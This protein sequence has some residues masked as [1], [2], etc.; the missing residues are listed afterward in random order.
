MAEKTAIVTLAIGEFYHNMA[1]YTHPLMKAYANKVN[2]EFVSIEEPNISK[3]TEL[4]LKY[5]KFQIYDLLED[6]DRLIFVDT[7][8]IVNPEAPDLFL[9]CPYDKFSAVSEE[10]FSG[11]KLEKKI[12]QQILGKVKWSIPY[13][14]TGVMVI[15]KRY[16]YIFDYNKSELK[17][18]AIGS[19]RREYP[20]ILN[21]QPYISYSLNKY[22][23][24]FFELDYRFN[25]T[26]CYPGSSRRFKSFFIHYSG[27]SGHRYGE[28]LKQIEMDSL[29]ARSS[30]KRK[31]STYLPSYRWFSDR[32]NLDFIKYL[33]SK[34]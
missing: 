32:M 4:P 13:I 33:L 11:A 17:S 7:D 14:N 3:K 29:V 34:D 26:R 15:P 9:L 25:H 1:E 28:R 2:A 10:A 31:L 16:R 24:D 8:I 30:I 21:D 6:Y 19:F 23:V 18:W 5:E 22:N 20:L 27:P 12:T